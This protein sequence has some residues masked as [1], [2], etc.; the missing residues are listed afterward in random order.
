MLLRNPSQL[1]RGRRLLLCVIACVGCGGSGSSITDESPPPPSSVERA[2]DLLQARAAIDNRIANL[3][4]GK[5]RV[6]DSSVSFPMEIEGIPVAGGAIT[7]FFDPDGNDRVMVPEVASLPSAATYVPVDRSGLVFVRFE[8]QRRLVRVMEHATTVEWIDPTTNEVL[9]VQP[10]AKFDRGT[11]N[12]KNF[13]LV[14]IDTERLSSGTYRLFDQGRNHEVLSNCTP[15][16][17]SPPVCNEGRVSYNDLDNVW[18]TSFEFG[19][20]ALT[21]QNNWLNGD[22]QT[23]A[24]EGKYILATEDDFIAANS[25]HGYGLTAHGLN[26]ILFSSLT[27]RSQTYNTPKGQIFIDNR[28]IVNCGSI[29]GSVPI[30]GF[31]KLDHFDRLANC[32]LAGIAKTCII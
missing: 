15:S 9:L 6:T 32:S 24:A 31:K 4:Y 13:G 7:V 5:P 14:T 26:L 29:L 8:G 17:T 23:T 21:S 18:G 10:S 28:D 19:A 3:N 30:I 20:R 22:G 27:G 11:A 1:R 25:V 12:T 2:H 16:G